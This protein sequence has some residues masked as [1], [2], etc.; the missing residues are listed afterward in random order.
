M[1]Q[2]TTYK[3]AKSKFDMAGVIARI[4]K[5][6]RKKLKKTVSR[7]KIRQVWKDYVDIEITEKLVEKGKVQ[8]D[9][10]FSLEIVGRRLIDDKKRMNLLTNG[11]GKKKLSQTRHG[12]TYRIAMAEERFKEGVL[13]FDADKRIKKAMNYALE[14]TNRYYRIENV[15]K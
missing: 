13:M 2:K 9:K 15:N 11:V 3:R 6:F 12:Y 7:S 1:T 10:K 5:R 8:I 14:N 4:K